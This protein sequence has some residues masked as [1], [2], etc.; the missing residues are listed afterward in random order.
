MYTANIGRLVNKLSKEFGKPLDDVLFDVI[1][2]ES[3]KHSY[4]YS[5]GKI[6]SLGS[7]YFLSSIGSVRERYKNV[8]RYNK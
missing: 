3:R 4:N 7:S 8:R 2:E 1:R 6:S 5:T